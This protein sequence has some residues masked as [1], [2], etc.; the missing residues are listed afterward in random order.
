MHRYERAFVQLTAKAAGLSEQEVQGL[1]R[2]PEPKLGDLSLPCFSLAKKLKK[3]PALIAGDIAQEIEDSPLFEKIEAV[4]PYINATINPAH[5]MPTVISEVRTLS[6]DFCRDDIGSGQTVVIDYSSPNIAKPLGFHHLRSTMIGNALARIHSMLGYRVVGINFLGDWGKTFGL[7]AEAFRRFGDSGK[8]ESGG[9][10]YLLELYVLANKAAKEDPSFDDAARMM[11]LRQ[12][13]GDAEAVGMWKLFRSISLDEFQKIYGRL[14]VTFDFIEGESHYSHGMDD[15]IASVTEKAGT[16]EDQG[17]L[18]VDMPYEEGEPPMMLRKSDGATLYAT[19]DIAAAIDRWNRFAFAKS[20]YVV[21][22]E[23]K[24]H[25][26]QLKRALKAMGHDWA[27]SMTHVYFG[28]IQGMSTRKGNVVFLEEVLDEAKA[29]AEEKISE[30]AGDR[31]IDMETVPEQVGVGGIVFGDLKNLRTSDYSFDWE[32]V[33]NP[34]G[35]TG[36]CV[37]YANARCCSI[38]AKGGGAPESADVDLSLLRA[39]EEVALAKELARLPGAVQAA[40]N[41]LEPSKLARALYEI[42]HAWNRYQQAGNADKM[43]RI[44]TADDALKTARLALV[45]AV[46]IGLSGGLELLGVPHPN[47]M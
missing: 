19:R 18:V 41:D 11:F 6:S 35:F 36:I 43:L 2:A 44:L 37:Q 13:E 32:E 22:V 26:E 25:F 9:I 45:D 29:R 39:P 5:L 28:R 30:T 4:G 16:R 20:L 10:A 15:V 33:L 14:D 42:A 21:G 8:L 47:A 12:E 40:A 34:K 24:R 17:A 38:L 46:R 23:Q 31:E 3:N 27:N 7:L 1:V